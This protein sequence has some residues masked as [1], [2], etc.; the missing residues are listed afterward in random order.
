MNSSEIDYFHHSHNQPGPT[1]LLTPRRLHSFFRKIS[2]N[3]QKE[4]GTFDKD[5]VSGAYSSSSHHE[6]KLMLNMP[7][8]S[9]DDTL[10][11][12]DEINKESSNTHMPE[13]AIDYIHQHKIDS[14]E[15]AENEVTNKAKLKWTK[16]LDRLKLISALTSNKK[17]SEASNPPNNTKNLLPSCYPPVLLAPFVFFQRDEYDRKVISITDTEVDQAI[18]H[19]LRMFRIELQYGEIKWIIY[20]SIAEFYNLHLTIKFK[21]ASGLSENP[22]P[23]FPNRLTLTS[24][25]FAKEEEDMSKDIFLKRRDE[26]ERYL[27]ELIQITRTSV[28]YEICE[29]LELS[30]ISV[31]K[32]IGWKGKEGYLEYNANPVSHSLL[33][34]FKSNRWLREWVVLRDSYIAFCTDITST[35]P[36]D[37]FLLDKHFEFT[38]FEKK[39]GTI[40]HTYFILSNSSRRIEIKA[41]ANRHIDEWVKGLKWMKDNSPWIEENRYGSYAPKRNNVKAKWFVDGQDYYDAVAEAILSAKSEIFIEDWWLSPQLYLKRPSKGNE[42]YRLDRLL[43]RKAYQGIK[44]Y[45]VIYKNVSVA[46]PLDSQHTRDWMHNIHPNIIV[47]RHANLATSP[48][49]AHHEKILV[50]DHCLA[51]VGGL[52]LCFGRYDSY[53][54]RLTDDSIDRELFPGQD[55]SNPRIKDFYK[56]SQYDL[57]LIDK[58]V[59]ARMPWHDIHTAMTGSAAGDIARHFIQRWNF[60]KS[61]RSK[62]RPDI[63][64]LLPRGEIVITKDESKYR[65]TCSVQLLRSS[66]EWSLGIKREFSIYNAYMNVISHAKHFIYIENQF[67]ITTSSSNDKLINNKIGQA[68]VERIKKAHRE[69][70][71]FRV[72]VVVPVAPGFE[73]DFTQVER[74]S[75]PLRSVAQYNYRSISRGKH[76]IF[77]HLKEANIPIKDYIG[78]YSLRKWD[79][80]KSTTSSIAP[81]QAEDNP[82]KS[83]NSNLPNFSHKLSKS[84]LKKSITIHPN[85]TK[86]T[87]NPIK[88]TPNENK[89]TYES[90]HLFKS[91]DVITEQIY[92]H[93]KLMIVD[94]RIVICGSANINDRSLLGNRDSEIA[95]IVEDTDMIDSKMNGKPQYKASRY[96]QSLRMQL[97]KEHLGLL[98]CPD[99][100]KDQY[101]NIK[102]EDVVVMDPLND[103]FYYDVWD[104]TAHN[105]TLLFRKLF[106]CIPD[107]TVHTVDQYRHFIPDPLKVPS[108]HLAETNYTTDMLQTKLHEIQGHLVEYPT[109]FMKDINMTS[110]SSSTP[111]RSIHCHHSS[112][113]YFLSDSTKTGNL[114]VLAPRPISLGHENCQSANSIRTVL[115]R[116]IAVASVTEC[117]ND[118]CPYIDNN[119]R[120]RNES[121]DR[122]HKKQKVTE[123][124]VLTEGALCKWSRCYAKF[125]KV[126]ELTPH[127]FKYH[128]N[129]NRKRQLTNKCFWESCSEV[130]DGQSLVTH[131]TK[132]LP[133][134]HGCQW[135]DCA[136]RYESF[137][138]LTVHLSDSHVGSGKSEYHCQW[139]NCDRRGRP[140]TQKQ[141]IMRHIQTHTGDKPFECGVCQRRFSESTVMMQ[142]MRVHTGEKPYRCDT[143]SKEFSVSAALTVHKRLHTGERP[144]LCRYKDC[145]RKFAESS[146][147]T[148][149]VRV[150]T[151]EKP[152]RCT[153]EPCGKAFSRPDQVTRHLKTHRCI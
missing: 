108:G 80:I 52:D 135:V 20:R 33:T 84:K 29:F 143:C 4:E 93:S 145:D 100:Q 99:D 81:N 16:P 146:N 37:V 120:N 96:A 149:H 65:G 64:F 9:T 3:V 106:R 86:H 88:H 131:L 17:S 61:N 30:A 97:F 95:V 128:V 129:N 136:E 11:T 85:P 48:F 150:H 45:I 103:E 58:K 133:L 121:G 147:L 152:F 34:V 92:I 82:I 21:Y 51:F 75:M 67:F 55:Y 72:I 25:R 13:T 127:I 1:D 91:N 139:I 50:I 140:F 38:Q 126:D 39:F 142:H 87:P 69:N 28:P 74:K 73:G 118:C 31:K 109:D 122:E 47:Q 24:L 46:L 89:A 124:S 6:R 40:H 107:D 14:G 5:I 56:V 71:K 27:K 79:Q 132:H 105:N 77:G 2:I 151:G 112:L 76:S 18:T 12:V 41:I 137:D 7:L 90:S 111:S 49:W 62:E 35:T 60:I 153:V 57:Q 125:Q 113:F 110:S 10:P 101:K 22:P 53:D 44:I 123:E 19:K 36:T 138:H 116:P 130:L 63:P 70:K 54:H 134:I 102:K 144:F 148:K 66:A 26:L 15:D 32:N 114:P 43:Q 98:N 59:I 83:D 23:S 141:K 104:K 68:L 94:D 115:P 42:E 78:F 117:C 8:G 119:K